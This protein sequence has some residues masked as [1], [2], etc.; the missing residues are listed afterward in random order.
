MSVD[1]IIWQPTPTQ[2]IL[3]ALQ[4]ATLLATT[5][6]CSSHAKR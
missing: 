4:N 5:L 1:P 2:L 6:L 3:N